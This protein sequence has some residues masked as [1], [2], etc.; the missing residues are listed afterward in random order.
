VVYNA[1]AHP[2]PHH[3]VT[4]RAATY[5]QCNARSGLSPQP[6]F[7][8]PVDHFVERS[9]S[10]PDRPT[11]IVDFDHWGAVRLLQALWRKG[12][13]FPDDF[14][15]ATFNRHVPGH[16]GYSAAHHRFAS[17][18]A[19]AEEAVRMLLGAAIRSG[20]QTPPQ[21]IVLKETLVVSRE[22]TAPPRA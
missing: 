3:S 5:Q 16:R 18:E 2:P 4:V 8:G 6:P 17:R 15:V 1:G 21:T 14:S 22:H 13:A 10:S 9:S 19:D 7:V 12:S 11:A 20:P